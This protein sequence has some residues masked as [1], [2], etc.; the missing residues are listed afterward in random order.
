MAANDNGALATIFRAISSARVNTW[1]G[2][3]TWF[4]N[5]SSLAFSA[6]IKSP[7][8]NIS[9]AMFFGNTCANNAGP[10]TEAIPRFT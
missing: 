3:T 5:I 9:K 2:S 7:V 6:S 4:T 10:L 1:S 8:N